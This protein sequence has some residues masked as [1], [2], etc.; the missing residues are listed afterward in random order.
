MYSTCSG[1]DLTI[2]EKKETPMMKE[3]RSKS[4]SC[5]SSQSSWL[6]PPVFRLVFLVVVSAKSSC[7][8]KR[9]YP[10]ENISDPEFQ[11]GVLRSILNRLGQCPLEPLPQKENWNVLIDCACQG[12]RVELG[13]AQLPLRL[14]GCMA[15]R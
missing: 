6:C 10:K 7:C 1:G 4:S 5:P 3:S 15:E 11:A 2:I 9:P 13:W 14:T 12:P 8:H